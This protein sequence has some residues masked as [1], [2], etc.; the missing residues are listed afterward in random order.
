M[1][2]F[3][4]VLRSPSLHPARQLFPARTQ[5]LLPAGHALQIH[6]EVCAHEAIT[7]SVSLLRQV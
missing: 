7:N 5:V 3:S 4:F 6:E 1:A 2:A